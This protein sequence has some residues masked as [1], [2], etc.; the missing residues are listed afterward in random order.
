MEIARDDVQL[1]GA[2]HV[3]VDAGPL[4]AG[5]ELHLDRALHA[6]APELADA[7]ARR[8]VAH[9]RRRRVRRRD[10]AD[11]ERLRRAE[12]EGGLDALDLAEM[13]SPDAAARD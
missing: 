4:R 7:N 9:V 10:A 11:V 13:F 8:V 2:G 1:F 3:I 6:A 12:T 5:I